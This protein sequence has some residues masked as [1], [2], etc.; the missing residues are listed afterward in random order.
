MALAALVTAAAFCLAW[1]CGFT[2]RTNDDVDMRMIAEG[3][4]NGRPSEFLIYQNVIAGLALRALYGVAPHVPWYD[5]ALAAG[6]IA[7]ALTL[8]TALLRLCGSHRAMI[9]CALLGLIVFAGI[10]QNLQ[11]T[12]AATLLA[13]GATALLASVAFRPPASPRRLRLCVA[14]AAAAFFW[15]SLFRFEAA[16]LAAALVAPILL[17]W[18]RQ[19][20]AALRLPLLGLAAGI[21]LAVSGKAF[22][23]AYYR[24]TPGWEHFFAEKQQ[25][26]RVSEYL[27]ADLSREPEM[28]AALAAVGWS[29]NDYDLFSG[30]MDAVP[31]TFSTERV[32]RFAELAPRKSRSERIATFLQ[33]TPPARHTVW[34]FV[35]LGVLALVMARSFYALAVLLVSAAWFAVL[36]IALAITYKPWFLHL[37]WMMGG[38]ALLVATAT[39]LAAAPRTQRQ[40]YHFVEDKMIAAG[41]LA[42][43]CAAALWQ[44]HSMWASERPR[45]ELRAPLARDLSAWPAAPNT[46]VVSWNADFPLETWVRPFHAIS[47]YGWRF[48][49]TTHTS[50]TP[51]ADPIYAVWGN[52]D[53]LWSLCHTPGTYL[54]D[55]RRGYIAR[56]AHM[57]STYM[58]EHHAEAVALVPVFE[59]EATSLLACRPPGKKD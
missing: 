47:R 45:D 28:K 51:L 23:V 37:L 11:F 42:A 57:L 35:T 25:R 16:F 55:G 1:F 34:L 58:R 6:S 14:A 56:H 5:L 21:A 13:G 30:R 50:G 22:D 19:S 40:G 15:G 44:V 7:G 31:D 39:A 2:Y 29:R 20:M 52:K 33:T 26:L 32:A 48:L 41:V 36:L 49:R 3:I 38:T 53:I 54:V 46:T 12:A 4:V 24:F 27:H 9:L 18:T 59:G 43:V 17:L 10:F 8:L